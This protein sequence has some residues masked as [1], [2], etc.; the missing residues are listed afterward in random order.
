M[1]ALRYNDLSDIAEAVRSLNP[2][3]LKVSASIPF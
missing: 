3:L 1:Y 2:T